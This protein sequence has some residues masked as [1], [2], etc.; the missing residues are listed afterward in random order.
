M[1]RGRS[2]VCAAAIRRAVASF[3]MPVAMTVELSGSVDGRTMNLL[4]PCRVVFPRSWGTS[5]AG[6]ARVLGSVTLDESVNCYYLLRP[7]SQRP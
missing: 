3:S 7:S 5:L 2:G 4:C 1:G 6:R